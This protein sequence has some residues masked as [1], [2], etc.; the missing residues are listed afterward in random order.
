[1]KIKL[2]LIFY[3]IIFLAF[4]SFLIAGSEQGV[5]GPLYLSSGWTLPKGDFTFHTNS[6]F[7]FNNKTFYSSD[8]SV[9]AITYWDIHGSLEFYYGFAKHF[10]AGLSQILYQD[11]HKGAGGYN[12]PDDLFLNLK[13]G[14][15]SAKSGAWNFGGK[16]MVRIPLADH[17]NIILEPYSAGQIEAGIFGLASYSSSPN[18]PESKLNVHLN[19]GLLDHND[20]A[21]NLNESETLTDLKKHN[22]REIIG[23]AAV[24][25]PTSLFDFS[26]ELYGNY[27]ISKPP[28][29]AFS[30]HNYLYF[31]PGITYKS[32]YWLSFA[33]GFDIRLTPNKSSASSLINS[34]LPNYLPTYPRWRVNFKMRVNPVSKLKKRFA[35]EETDTVISTENKEK[36]VYEKIADEKK[37]IEKA[38]VE[39][40]NIIKQRQKLDEILNR[41]KKALDVKNSEKNG[42]GKEKK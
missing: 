37:H 30:R 19:L 33:F 31:S 10:Q 16:L 7:Y 8:N 18:F 38:E 13:T 25:F 20:H 3:F 9:S 5:S 1:M 42:E 12:F 39:L 22:S 35:K 21:V 24:I 29:T 41:L 17:H 6:R 15:F 14:G 34:D 11:N 28:A 4:S 26:A 2:Y 40:E 23:G 32:F 36:T 27:Y